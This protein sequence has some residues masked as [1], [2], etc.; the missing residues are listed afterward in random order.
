MQI[1]VSLGQIVTSGVVLVLAGTVRTLWSTVVE[2]AKLK[3]RVDDH[4]RRLEKVEA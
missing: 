1:D 2:L 3:V 4:A